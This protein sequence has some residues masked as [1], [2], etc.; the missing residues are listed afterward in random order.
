MNLLNEDLT[1]VDISRPVLKKG[2]PL[3]FVVA[4]MKKEKTK[5][6]ANQSDDKASWMLVTTF[7][8]VFPWEGTKEGERINAGFT[9]TERVMLTP[10]EGKGDK[11]GRDEE[12]ILKDLK[13][14]RMAI[15]GEE[16]GS[17][18]NFL[19]LDQYLR[20]EV[21]AIIDIEEDESGQYGPQNRLRKMQPASTPK[22]A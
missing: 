13:R 16:K 9:L 8:T 12:M 11:R 7:K 3:R 2:G 5:A 4:E 10:T 14:L 21:D 17:V 6:T 18:G 20:K 22:A 15:L 19:P 1:K